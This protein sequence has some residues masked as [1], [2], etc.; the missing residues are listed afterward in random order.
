ML[1]LMTRDCP[2]QQLNAMYLRLSFEELET[3]F[4][5]LC[6]VNVFLRRVFIQSQRD[7][8]YLK[9]TDDVG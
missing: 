4:R 9:Y 3:L 1:W 5:V 6:S 7:D 2:R 8:S